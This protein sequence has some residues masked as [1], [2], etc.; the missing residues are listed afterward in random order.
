MFSRPIKFDT[1]PIQVK[2][3]TVDAALEAR[4]RLD[5][6]RDR[7]FGLNVVR[8]GIVAAALLPDVKKNSSV[9]V[10]DVDPNNQLEITAL[11]ALVAISQNDVPIIVITDD[12]AGETARQLLRLQVSDWL[13]RQADQSDLVQ[14]CERAIKSKEA[15]GRGHEARCYAF[16]PAVGGVGNT[17]LAIGSAF[18]LAGGKRPSRS[19]CLVDLDLQSGAIAD[20]LDLTANM[21][22]EDVARTP[23]RLDNHLLEVLLSRHASGITLLAAPNSLTG[24]DAVEHELVTRLLDLAASRFADLVIDLPRQ[25]LPWS[26]GILRGAD[27]FFIVT[28]LS[29]PGLRQA[30]RIA[31]EMHKRFDLPSKGRVIVNK[32]RWLGSH[33]VKKSDAYEALGERLAGFVAET[34]SL[35]RESHNRGVPLS[36]LKR[37]NRLEKDLAAILQSAHAHSQSPGG[38]A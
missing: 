22:L 34:G 15:N 11:E 18:V 35:V 23:A 37:S 30:R 10:I 36:E 20:Y 19:V 6:G 26:E 38:S 33:G 4:L 21:Q 8:S 27:Q 12:L 14:A 17:T 29:V 5:L 28:E 7:R 32:Y 1:P 13:P 16:Y 2:L 31:D 3:V 24:F 25:W 9:L